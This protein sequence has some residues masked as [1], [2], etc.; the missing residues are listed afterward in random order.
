VCNWLQYSIPTIP[1]FPNAFMSA[2]K[3]GVIF[4]CF[5]KC[6]P[7]GVASNRFSETLNR[8]MTF[9]CYFPLGSSGKDE[10][11]SVQVRYYHPVTLCVGA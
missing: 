6:I 1:P 10:N 2:S 7:L 11:V 5:L 8:C 4:E 9:L 3:V